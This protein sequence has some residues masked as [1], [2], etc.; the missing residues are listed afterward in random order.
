[1]NNFWDRKKFSW[2]KDSYRVLDVAGYNYV[3]RK[4]ESDHAAYPERIIY[5]SFY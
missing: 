4:Y 2:D 3:R 5:G 1:M